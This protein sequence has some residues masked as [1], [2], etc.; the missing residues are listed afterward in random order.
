MKISDCRKKQMV[1]NII[2]YG[3][4]IVI[5]IW[6]LQG[7]NNF[8]IDEMFSYGL[9]NCVGSIEMLPPEEGKVF[10][11]TKE[12][13]YEY[14]TVAEDQRFNYENVW[15]NQQA[16][17]HPPLYYSILHTICSIWPGTF[18]IWYAGIINIAAVVFSL[19]AVRKILDL[20]E[21]NLLNKSIVSGLFIFSTGVWSA[22]SFLRMYA[23]TMFWTTLTAYIFLRT[24]KEKQLF[25]KDFIT[26]FVVAVC[27]ALTHYY[28]LVYLF[29]LCVVYF[30]YLVFND[31]KKIILYLVTYAAAG[32]TAIKIFPAMIFHMFE[33]YRGEESIE[34]LNAFSIENFWD[35]FKIFKD[36]VDTQL[37]AGYFTV[38]LIISIIVLIVR[39]TW[40][41]ID[42]KKIECKNV[43]WFWSVLI[44]PCICY[45]ALVTQMAVYT[46]ARY[47]I[48]IYGGLI[49]SVFGVLFQTI[50][51]AAPEV[52]GRII[53]CLTG[54]FIIGSMVIKNQCD[55]RRLSVEETDIIEKY[56]DNDC[57]YVHDGSWR[58]Q[59][60]FAE[61]RNYES[62]RFFTEDN[63]YTYSELEKEKDDLIVAIV[64]ECDT[65]AV[66]KKVLELYPELKQYEKV[67]SFAYS[68]TFY[69]SK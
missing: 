52:F 64:S 37:F 55:F 32:F 59:A 41:G 45:F 12:A 50:S 17:V 63:F 30:V 26:M 43:G 16:D 56:A 2:V 23:L 66:V 13:Y 47:M 31:K 44:I 8:H 24:I 54:V 25:W 3:L 58:I 9:S 27:G 1:E 11:P 57:V 69:F 21:M 10:S 20:I 4:M 5:C 15:I 62:I 36:L 19:L 60:S 22:V 65:E 48:P 42:K 18:S 28:Y 34:N 46:D 35:R 40:A 39:F 53:I 6:L 14:L 49:V 29:F 7:K 33:D 51:K 68:D 61:M 38:L 67:G